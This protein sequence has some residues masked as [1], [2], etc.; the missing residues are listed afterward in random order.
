[1]N[2]I[3]D[4]PQRTS[5]PSGR[6][7]TWW[8]RV[9]FAVLTPILE[10][11][12]RLYW[13]TLKFEIHEH[14]S[15]DGIVRSGRPV[16][17]AIWHENLLGLSRFVKIFHL[18]GGWPTF[19]IS[20]SVDG[21]IGVLLLARFG[22]KA[23][24]GSARRSG[25][26][27]LRGLKVAIQEERQSPIITLDGS[28]GPRR[29]AK[30]GAI[31]VSR[32]AGV[33]IVPVACAARRAGR[34][35]TWDRHLVPCP[36]SKVV[37]SVGPPYTV[38]ATMDSAEKERCRQNLEQQLDAQLAAAEEYAGATPDTIAGTPSEEEA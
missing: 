19:L 34:L 25:A 12:L 24:R 31:M 38:P 11:S 17:F 9:L 26:A 21:E 5:R 20:P 2:E 6:Q 33:P 28:S 37:I 32:M 3:G 36:F 10:I 23:V 22:G 1:M 18:R 30:P 27:A 8:R 16:V 14:E 35:G 29:Y 4:K 13:L 7:M 15:F